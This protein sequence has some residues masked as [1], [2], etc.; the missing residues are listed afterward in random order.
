MSD[1]RITRKRKI[2]I[3]LT[4]Q[5][6][7]V[8][9]MA[10]LPL[11]DLYKIIIGISI[12][13]FQVFMAIYIGYIG[14]IIALFFN[15]TGLA[16]VI[17]TYFEDGDR[18]ALGVSL[19]IVSSIVGCGI[20]A[21]FTEKNWKIVKKLKDSGNIDYVT[22]SYNHNY[23]IKRIY[24]EIARAGRGGEHT[25]LLFLDID[26]FDN[27]NK[28]FGIKF[29]DKLLR[30]VSRHISM[31]LREYDTLFRNEGDEFSII[32]PNTGISEAEEIST[33]IRGAVYGLRS[34]ELLENKGLDITISV[35]FSSYPELA[36]GADDLISQGKAAL[37][38]AKQGGRN[39]HSLYF[40]IFSY[41]KKNL[42]SAESS[43]ME[44]LKVILWTLTS[45]DSY[46]FGHSERVAKYSVDIGKCIGLEKQDLI[47]LEITALL[48]DIG[49]ID[50]PL[51]VLNKRGKLT[52]DEFITIQSHTLEGAR[53][54][55]PIKH[56]HGLIDGVTHHHEKYNGS[57]YPKGLKGDNIPLIARIIAIADAYDAMRSDRPYRNGLTL[58]QTS[59]VIMENLGIQFDPELGALFL[60]KCTPDYL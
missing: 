24:S 31:E 48:H 23:F 44:N 38:T 1:S 13:I 11:N 20:I 9:L 34:N 42:P 33:R 14:A 36:P 6:V 40:D 56:I 16:A 39:K 35:G 15:L 54:L 4:L 7:L 29:G 59:K 47:D 41:I 2:I 53:I 57:G 3:F 45:K 27:I 5:I 21:Y 18:M 46:T 8:T 55:K 58:N 49:K 10:L 51:S 12:Y 60:E 28:L 37:Y 43:F 25:S 26:H 30:L 17:I 50:I 22:G 52:P 19:F 32:L